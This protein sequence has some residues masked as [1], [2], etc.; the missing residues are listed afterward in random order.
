VRPRLALAL[1]A[2]LAAGAAACRP[3]PCADT[4]VSEARSLDGKWLAAS[5]ERSCGPDV[6]TQVALRRA[7]SSFSATDEEVVFA[8]RGR[9]R[10]QLQFGEEPVALLIETTARETLK[11]SPSWRS[12]GVQ[13]RRVR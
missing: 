9:E 5:F 12:V 4:V 13:V 8:L 1:L 2:P 10:L 11:E 3:H 6:T 7:G